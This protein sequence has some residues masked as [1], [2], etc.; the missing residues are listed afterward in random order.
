MNMERITEEEMFTNIALITAKRSPCKR[1]QVGCVIVKN[2]RLLSHGYNGFL[3]NCPHVSVV[4]DHHEQNTIHAEMNALTYCAKYGI[5][6]KDASMYVTHYPCL[7]CTK[8]ALS[9]GITSIKFLHDYKN[10]DLVKPMIDLSNA[11]IE[12]LCLQTE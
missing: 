4:R 11:N 3:P 12:Q 10:D 5:S 7:N 1:L 8:L 6:C 9:S 2:G